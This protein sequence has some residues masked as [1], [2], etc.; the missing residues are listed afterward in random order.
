MSKYTAPVVYKG[1]PKAFD[2]VTYEM[3]LAPACTDGCFGCCANCMVFGLTGGT[4][5]CGLHP[6]FT[7]QISEDGKRGTGTK[8]TVCGCIR[9]S[10]LPCFACCGYGPFAFVSPGVIVDTPEGKKWVG[11]GQVCAGGCCPCLNNKGDW[12][13]FDGTSD[14]SAPD[15]PGKMH[16]MSPFWPPCLHSNTKP[17]FFIM[18]KG[19]GPPKKNVMLRDV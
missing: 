15:K 7:M 16:A 8:S 13:P 18:Q 14:G 1:D 2:G 5:L 12:T 3:H 11:D 4:H 19:V 10:P 9:N 6:T 17:V